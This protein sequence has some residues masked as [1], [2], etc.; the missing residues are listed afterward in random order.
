MKSAYVQGRFVPAEEAT[1]SVFDRG[2]ILGDGLFE[3]MRATGA[4]IPFWGRHLQR[5]LEGAADLGIPFHAES[6]GLSGIVT[7][8]LRRNALPESVVRIQ[9]SRGRGGRGYSPGNAG[10]PTLVVTVHE[11]PT[12]P[13]GGATWRLHT[14][15][16]RVQGRDPLAC[17]KTG[18][19]LRHILARAEAEAAG[20]DEALLLTEDG[21]ISEAAAANVFWL[22]GDAVFTP[23]L[24][25]GCLAGLTRSVLLTL[26]GRDG[27]RCSEVLAPAAELRQAEGVFL[28]LST[29]GIVEAVALDGVV[30]PRSDRLNLIREAY[31]RDYRSHLS[32]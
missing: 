31:L 21:T 7:E 18:S 24:E 2:F 20:A 26:L 29:L 11:A 5:L 8:L 1:V 12:V 15:S 25:A 23:A 16:L 27:W 22:R 17:R 32:G 3:T 28:T 19:R 6:S 14:A 10:P 9:L 13:P 30:L 4:V